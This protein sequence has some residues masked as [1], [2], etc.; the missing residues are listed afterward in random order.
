M[1]NWFAQAEASM[2]FL[3][4]WL[5]G[6][7]GLSDRRD[8][9]L[10]EELESHV[11]MH[12]EENLRA[13][14]TFAEARR[15]A[16]IKLGGIEQVK[17][18]CRD[19]RRFTGFESLVQDIR[20]GLRMLRKNPVVTLAVV[21]TLGLGLGAN[22]AIFSILNG[23][24]LKPLPVSH[25]EQIAALAVDQQDTPLGAI[26]L[27]YPEFLDFRDQTKAS[28]AMFANVLDTVELER[29]G[30]ADQVPVSYVSSDFFTI[31]GLNPAL[32]RLILPTDGD[33]FGETPLL[34]LGYS[35]WQKR[36]GGD[37]SVIGRPVRINGNQATI[38]G[39]S[40]K[41]FRGMFSPMEIDGY[42][43]LG[44]ISIEESSDRFLTDRR[45]RRVLA[46]GRLKPG[47]TFRQAQNSLDVIA[48]R[49]A[50]TYPDTD[51]G[52]R[53]RA[54]PEKLARPQPY[55]NSAFLVIGGLFL[56]FAGLV[57]LLA[58]MNVT[59][60]LLGRAL[61]RQ[62][63]MAIRAALGAP[64][65]R[66]IRQMLTETLML[67]LGGG[68][69]GLALAELANR[70]A[71]SLHL[72]NFPLRLD[73]SLDWRVCTYGFVAAV[74]AGIASGLPPALR[75][76][77]ADV[78]SVLRHEGLRGS[79]KHRLHDDLIVAQIAC[80]L[81]LLIA[82]G[83]FVRSLENVEG[84]DLGFQ[85]NHLLNVMMDPAEDGFNRVRT[86]G[87]YRDLEKRMKALPGVHSVSFARSV[88]IGSFPARMAVLTQPVEGNRQPPSILYNAVGPSYFE[89][90]KIPLVRGRGFTEADNETAPLVA[91][92]NETMANQFW[93]HLD[94]I[95][96]VFRLENAAGPRV[97]IVGIAHQGKYQTV[98]E[99]FQPYFYVPLRQHYTSRR[100][101]EIRTLVSPEALAPEVE[102]EIHALA[103][104]VSIIDLRTMKQ[105]LEGGT[106]YFIFRLGASLSVEMGLLGLLLAVVGV[107]GV[108]SFVVTERTR[109]IGIRMALGAQPRAILALA[110]KRGLTLVV[111]AVPIGWIGTLVLGRA[112][113]HF[114]VGVTA[115]DPLTYAV[116]TATLA[117]TALIACLI[118]AR[119]AMRI[120]P[121]V[122]LRHE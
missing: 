84:T 76:S 102:R 19:R 115:A 88:P 8:Q 100:V 119:R 42:L 114:L 113:D 3:R 68:C 20:F 109:E 94:P 13:G 14:M 26:G 12:V 85:P 108:V 82:G 38:I 34:V 93:A 49:L 28:S 105:W 116:A 61:I 86:E 57:L 77:R 10:S 75:A 90:M 30:T 24:L 80:S 83:L 31:L 72:P 32:G 15:R 25:P 36:F 63:E 6:S 29:D 9:E 117:S 98:A 107:Y 39:V 101:L 11:Q 89:T 99:N 65:S 43:P 120:D 54:I 44:A 64:R 23:F 56:A 62:R 87:F 58:S 79:G 52:V 112:L 59:N 111:L 69:A 97:E 92:V 4:A 37:P 110:L 78:N 17:E 40:P 51:A 81:M 50:L 16:L 71:P 45:E 33:Q 60:I 67:A 47:M 70:L 66:M 55:A 35:Y 1:R 48:S 104:N 103:A 5:L 95:G 7:I 122:A 21:I 22:T 27:S 91:I 118:P 2:R 96:Q 53:L 106:G 121:M 74:F 41:S 73:F 18:N 46:F